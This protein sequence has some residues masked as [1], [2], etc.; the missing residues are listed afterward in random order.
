MKRLL[1]IIGI[2]VFLSG[3][4]MLRAQ[5]PIILMPEDRIYTL[6]AGTP[7]SLE[8]DK[9][10]IA[11]TFTKDMKVVDATTLIRQEEDRKNEV[12]KRIKVQKSKN[13]WMKI[14]GGIITSLSGII[15]LLLKNKKK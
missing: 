10:P 1:S 2:I 7:A 6:K 3:C 13:N 11:M 5:R 8:L 9:K 14:G 4:S 12:L 15:A